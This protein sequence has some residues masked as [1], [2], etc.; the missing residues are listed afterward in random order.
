A[1]PVDAAPDLE[2]HVRLVGVDQLR[3]DDARVRPERLL[4]QVPDRSGI[5]LHVVVADQEKV[6]VPDH[7]QRL[8]RG[9]SEPGTRHLPHGRLREDAPDAV[10]GVVV[11]RGVDHEDGEA[12]VVLAPERLQRRLEPRS[13]VPGD[14]D[15]GD[16]GD[17]DRGP[18]SVLLAVS[19]KPLRAGRF[20]HRHDRG[21]VYKLAP[22][23]VT[24][25]T[26]ACNCLSLRLLWQ[27]LSP[28]ESSSMDFDPG[29]TLKDAAYITVG[30]G[31]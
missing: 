22:A 25:V 24:M 13:R 26:S 7:G 18:R 16:G 27:A 8:V 30:V 17:L 20:R 19:R 10:S 6:R 29:K 15:G 11:G 1:E 5:E 21:E 3:A 2:Q 12:R 31:V 23:L 14:D 9:A 4:E 28:K